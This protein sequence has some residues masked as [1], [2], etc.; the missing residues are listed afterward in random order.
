MTEGSIIDAEQAA[1]DIK[2]SYDSL[3]DDFQH[4]ASLALH[5]GMKVSQSSAALARIKIQ[6]DAMS[7][8]TAVRIR[9][10]NAKDGV[11]ITEPALKEL[12]S[13]DP[14][15][16]KMK[17]KLVELSSEH[18]CCRNAFEAFKHRRDML[19]QMSKTI[20]EE[21]R[22]EMRMGGPGPDDLAQRERVGNLMKKPSAA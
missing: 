21:R 18:E 11:K 5:Y 9:A 17:L 8:Q 13:I 4:H 12:V 14:K 22:G 3:S 15:L 7:A 2:T 16:V 19:V 1:K 6:I 10:Q 20:L